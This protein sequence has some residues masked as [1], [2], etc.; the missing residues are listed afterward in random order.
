MMIERERA[1]F[2]PDSRFPLL[3]QASNEGGRTMSVF[4]TSP[5]YIYVQRV[6]RDSAGALLDIWKREAI[7]TV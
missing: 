6:G 2:N 1:D 4:P 3:W 5:L 7:S